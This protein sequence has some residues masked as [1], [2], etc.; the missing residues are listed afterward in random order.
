MAQV[1]IGERKAE[2]AEV[3][4]HRVALRQAVFAAGLS[5][6]RL[7]ADGTIMVH[8][9]DPGYRPLIRFAAN[10]ARIVGTY[11]HVITDDVPAAQV[12]AP[13]L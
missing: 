8:T 1:G 9:D 12:D 11:V 7:R 5:R 10:A 3:E 13:D 2:R 6:P 4:P